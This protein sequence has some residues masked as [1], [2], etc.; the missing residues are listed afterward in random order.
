MLALP[1][2]LNKRHR[3]RVAASI[4]VHIVPTYVHVERGRTASVSVRLEEGLGRVKG[5][6]EARLTTRYL[7]KQRQIHGGYTLRSYSW[8]GSNFSKIKHLKMISSSSG[9]RIKQDDARGEFLSPRG[10]VK[11]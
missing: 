11:I 7:L 4:S 5:D 3:V 2:S 1:V 10:I 9:I 6:D 8:V